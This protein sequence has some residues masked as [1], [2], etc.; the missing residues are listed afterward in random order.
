MKEE[1]VALLANHTWD[2]VPR[3]P[4]T[5]V[6]TGKWL[7]RHKLTLDGSLDRYKG[8]WVVRGFTQHPRV[9][10]YETFSPVVKFATVCA[11]LSLALSR[12]WAIHQ[13]DVKNAFLHGTLMETIYCSQPIG[14]INAA[15]LDLVCR[16]NR[17]L[18]GLKQ[19]SR[20]WYS[21]FATYLASISFV[22][23][24]SDTSLFIYRWG[25]ETVYL[26]LYVDDIVLTASTADLLQRMIIAL[27]REIAMKD[28][29][30]LH[31]FLGITAECRPQGLFMYQRQYAI[32]ILERAGMSDY[33]ADSMPV[34]TQTK[35]F[36]DDGPP[37]A[38]VTSYHSLIGALQHHLL[39]VRHRL[40]RPTGVSPYAHSARAPSHRSQADPVLPLELPRLRPPA[41]TILDVRT[42]GLN[43]R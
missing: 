16:L 36:E 7:F 37:T 12:N 3:P 33:K 17:S 11:I 28:L 25:E 24:K 13:L 32:N 14:F 22:E 39:P 20:A 2:L 40:L 15:H 8:H 9:D 5:N 34:D 19:A 29:G 35:L 10:Y 6:V 30:P 41:P 18:Y 27:Q 38:D 31:H 43:R 1:Y 21:R 4:G 42:C 23:A 26:L